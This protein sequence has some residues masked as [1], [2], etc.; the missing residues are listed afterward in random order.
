MK[1]TSEDV[2]L[3][4]FIFGG[5]NGIASNNNLKNLIKYPNANS[6]SNSKY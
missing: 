6:G 4:G 5:L 3:T 1:N 2:K